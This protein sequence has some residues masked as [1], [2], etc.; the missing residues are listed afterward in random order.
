MKFLLTCIN[1]FFAFA[2]T[3][4]QVKK[5]TVSA[6]P[7][8]STT[9]VIPVSNAELGTFPYFKT[10]PNFTPTNSSDSIT[11]EQNRTYF[12]NGSSYIIVDGQVSAQILN[13]IDDTKKTP[14]EFQI[15][16]E[17]D[18]IVSTLGGKKIYSGRLPED[19]LKTV[20]GL[21]IVSLGTKNQVAPSAYYGVV[22]YVIKTPSKEVWVQL[23]PG[24]IASRFYNLLVVEKQ[25]P[26]L[27]TNINK[28][29]IIL[30]DVEK[31]GKA[32]F[33]LFFDVDAATLLT[34]S[35]DELLDIVNIYQQHPDWK[36]RLEIHSAPI[37][38]PE[39][40]LALTE[41]RAAAIKDELITLGVKATQLDAKGMGDAKPIT[42]NETEK[43]RLDNTRVQIIKM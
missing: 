33:N 2:V 16:Q 13:V 7:T 23:V 24:T 30:Q 41:K 32:T 28:T 26:L 3:E 34:A 29:N 5:P 35:K 12:F 8:A 6:K 10:L 38:K 43:G 14:S 15:V 39:Y 19:K 18:K 31:N 40:T 11:V 1:L 22:E 37:G 20:S 36:L 17:F 42:S 21:D 25:S 4:A 27:T 9:D